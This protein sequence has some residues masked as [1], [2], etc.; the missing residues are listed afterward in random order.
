MAQAEAAETP[1]T[2]GAMTKAALKLVA[3]AASGAMVWPR[4]TRLEAQGSP[5][6]TP[7]A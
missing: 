2:K 4:S 1:A 7:C 3:D 6:R 5:V